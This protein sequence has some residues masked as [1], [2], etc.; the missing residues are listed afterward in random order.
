[1]KCICRYMY[2]YRCTKTK[3]I[4]VKETCVISILYKYTD[5]KRLLYIRY[6]VHVCHRTPVYVKLQQLN[7]A[8]GNPGDHKVLPLDFV[9]DSVGVVAVLLLK[10]GN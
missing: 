10:M 6:H 5:D 1:M 4:Y 9:L 2:I 7:F 3:I 8:V